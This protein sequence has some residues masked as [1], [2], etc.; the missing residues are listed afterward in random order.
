MRMTGPLPLVSTDSFSWR[1]RGIP[2]K[3]PLSRCRRSLKRSQGSFI[4]GYREFVVIFE[5]EIIRLV[6]FEFD[7]ERRPVRPDLNNL[8]YFPTQVAGKKVV[9]LNTTC[10]S[11]AW[12]GLRLHLGLP[13]L[14]QPGVIRILSHLRPLAAPHITHWSVASES[15]QRRCIFLRLFTMGRGNPDLVLVFCILG[16]NSLR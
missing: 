9:A 8:D 12:L 13:L 16:R 14:I 5:V 10:W 6:L 2:V 11:F 7:D 3:M 4:N 1:I 15:T